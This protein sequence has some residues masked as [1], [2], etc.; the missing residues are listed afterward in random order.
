MSDSDGPYYRFLNSYMQGGR[1]WAVESDVASVF[2]GCGLVG[3]IAYVY[4]FC[5]FLKWCNRDCKGLA[6]AILIFA[7]MY[8]FSSLMIG[9]LT[10]SLLM[11]NVK[12]NRETASE[13]L[14]FA[15]S[16]TLGVLHA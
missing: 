1:S 4:L 6:V 13:D 5:H 11:A 14:S 10:Y 12:E 2:G 15:K 7:A 3:G 16:S 9:F 8:D